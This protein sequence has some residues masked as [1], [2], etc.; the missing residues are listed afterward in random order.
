MKTEY[1]PDE[2]LS[3]S[4]E[5][6]FDEEIEELLRHLLRENLSILLVSNNSDEIIAGRLSTIAKK[7]EHS[8]TMK[9]L[10]NPKLFTLYTFSTH[11]DEELNAFDKYEVDKAVNFLI[12]AVDRRYRRKGIATKI[13]DAAMKFYS[14]IGMERVVIKGEATSNFSKRIYEKFGFET[15]HEFHYEDYKVDGEVVFK[16]TGEH[17]SSKIFAKMVLS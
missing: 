11:K 10:K 14:E 2:P 15:L 4:L 5:I 3:R 9:N 1:A 8:D 6:V 16:K 17:K 7:N 12:L 13:M